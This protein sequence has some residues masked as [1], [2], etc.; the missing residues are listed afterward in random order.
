MSSP[1]QKSGVALGRLAEGLGLEPDE[2]LRRLSLAG[3][4]GLVRPDGTVELDAI[5]RIAQ[6]AREVPG[7]AMRVA[8]TV[9]DIMSQSGVARLDQVAAKRSSAKAA[10]SAKSGVPNGK[11]APARVNA[12]PPPVIGLQRAEVLREQVIDLER[13]LAEARL[14]LRDARER[15]QASEHELA[16]LRAEHARDAQRWEQRAAEDARRIADG[17]AALAQARSALAAAAGPR[18]DSLESVFRRRGLVGEDEAVAA[19]RVLLDSRRFAA[20]QGLLR[21]TEPNEA[22]SLLRAQVALHCGRED[23]P[24]P[25]GVSILRGSPERCEVC[26]GSDMR[27]GLRRFSEALMLEALLRVVVVGGSPGYHRMLREGVDRRV[28]LR[29]VAGDA[30][31]TGS[32]AQADLSWAQL[33]IIWGGTIL[34]HKVS[35]LYSGGPARTLRIAHRGL[36]GLLDQVVRALMSPP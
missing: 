29:L 33:V 2:L 36:S 24:A 12:P 3:L 15:A 34:D 18:E 26:E 32:Q 1:R 23:C 20:M 35:E 19:L 8:P 30:R 11:N 10:G 17:A 25:N 27:R 13:G 5:D 7:P 9:A 31:R 16:A 28:D 14:E 6:C 21:V 22:V 4:K